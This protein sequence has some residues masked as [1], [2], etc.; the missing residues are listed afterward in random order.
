MATWGFCK[1]G[2]QTSPDTRHGPCSADTLVVTTTAQQTWADQALQHPLVS[3]LRLLQI[4]GPPNPGEAA[5][6]ANQS[7]FCGLNLFSAA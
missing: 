2:A 4:S 1:E 7:L 6:L 3:T 5:L